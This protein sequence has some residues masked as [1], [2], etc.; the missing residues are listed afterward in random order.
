MSDKTNKK[1]MKKSEIAT[2]GIGL[3]G[4][5]LMT[6]W[7]PDY[8]ATFFADFAFKGKGFDADTMASAISM[9]FLVAGIVGAVCE[10]VIGYLVDN[11]RTKLGKVKPWIGFGVIPLSIIAMLVFV[12]PNTNNQTVAIAWMFIIYSLYTAFSCAVE[13]PSNC[14]GSLCSP[15]P[16]ERSSAISIASFLRSVGQSGGMVVILVVGLVMKAVMGEQ[17]FKNAEAQGLDLI[18]STAICALGLILF[19]M[20]F[21]TNNQE[22]VPFTQEKVSL[23][24]AVKVV[25][26]HKNL[27]MVSLTKLC[28]FGRGVYG[29]VSLYIAIYLLGSKDLKLALLLPMGIGTAVGTLLVN[30]VLKKF[31]T[32]KTFILFCLYGASS[33]SI[34]FLVSKGIGFNS[35]L[36][37]PFLILNFFCGLQHGNTN[38]T[39]NIMIADCVDEIEFK[40]GKRQEGLAYAGYGLF[41]KVASAFTK[42]LGPWLLYTWSGYLASTNANVAYAAQ[43]DA[44]LN[45]IL[46]IYTIIPAI[47][48]ILQA[49]PIFFYDMVG[50][51][52]E[53]I[54]KALIE[55][56]E[57]AAQTAVTT[58]A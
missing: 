12:A 7:M 21:F 52:K 5:A 23:K 25:F 1:Y 49:V 55:R 10:L 36:I 16:S 45:K 53:N 54:T 2:F 11:T 28:G 6:G 34:L 27:L 46:M 40:T 20:I 24:D 15:N 26:T 47:F 9:V 48:V 4:V 41:S 31:S 18:I 17:Q 30:I 22:R 8:T 38:V 33:L 13:S 43:T 35:T 50:E 44:T 57:K 42:A 19:V 3:F 56:R 58:E 39:P 14:F 51:K 29:T 32:K 37:I